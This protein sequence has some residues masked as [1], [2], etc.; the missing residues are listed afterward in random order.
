VGQ[1]I[2]LPDTLID[3][4]DWE[5]EA[6]GT[7]TATVDR[8]DEGCTSPDD[9][10]TWIN[11]DDGLVTVGT[12]FKCHLSDPVGTPD[13]STGPASW[14]VRTRAQYANGLPS[15]FLVTL[16]QGTTTITSYTP[17]LTA[18][19]ATYNLVFDPASITDAT[20][21][22]FEIDSAPNFSQYAK[23]TAIELIIKTVDPA[24]SSGG[25]KGADLLFELIGVK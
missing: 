21:L 25:S 17:T 23:V 7:G 9:G 24:S 5:N 12:V 1:E 19:W 11:Q 22:R 15:T 20:D 14:T 16:K 18:S 8:I 6:G 2:L 3:A 4:Q 13:T 10:T